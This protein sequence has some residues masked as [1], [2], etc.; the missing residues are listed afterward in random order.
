MSDTGEETFAPPPLLGQQTDKVLRDLLKKSNSDI[1]ELR[2][3][4]T[5]G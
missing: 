3:A 2:D 4:G 5:I 1:K